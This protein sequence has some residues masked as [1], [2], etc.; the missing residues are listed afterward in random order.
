MGGT[1]PID[2]AAAPLV[3]RR[4][5]D[6]V[7]LREIWDGRVWEARPAV[8]VR[9]DPNLTMLLVPPRVHCRVAVDPA[10]HEL[11]LPTGDWELAD[12][13][14]SDRS[15]LSFAFPD[16]PYAVILGYEED[17]SLREYYVN[18]QTPLARSTIGFDVVE[19]VLDVTIP[20]DRSSWSW[21]DEDELE[22]AI[23]RG[24]FT[25]EDA[26][27]FRYWGERAVEHILLREPPFDRDWDAW[28]PDP[29]WAEPTL[30]DGWELVPA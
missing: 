2:D 25:E 16:T 7:A 19:H 6:V 20:V 11:R 3:H 29:G 27:W 18:L 22:E 15:M 24:L 5:G 4:E 1:T 9:D 21:K 13:Q 12:V 30:P 23:E 8:V 10:G 28:R 26:A 14:R 17:G